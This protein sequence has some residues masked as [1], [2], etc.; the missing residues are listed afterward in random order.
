MV[1]G[2]RKRVVV[3]ERKKGRVMERVGERKKEKE[4]MSPPHTIIIWESEM[5]RGPHASEFEL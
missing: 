4:M 3:G 1:V 2:E 5:C